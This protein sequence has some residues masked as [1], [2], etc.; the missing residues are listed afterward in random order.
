MR[1]RDARWFR[2]Y[3]LLAAFVVLTVSA[4]LLTHYYSLNIYRQSVEENRLWAQKIESYERLE[5]SIAAIIAPGNEVFASIDPTREAE[6]YRTA[7][8]RY[9]EAM[10]EAERIAVVTARLTPDLDW[11]STLGEIDGLVSA[12]SSMTNETLALYGAN[13]ITEAA[14]R[15]VVADRL[16]G[17]ANAIIHLLQK[18]MRGLQEISLERQLSLTEEIRIAE[19]LIGSLVAL[20]VLALSLY[21]YRLSHRMAKNERRRIEQLRAVEASEQK[22]RE[23]AEGSIEGITVHRHGKPLFVNRTWAEFHNYHSPDAVIAVG[24]LSNI[25]AKEDREAVRRI[26]YS[27]Q[28]GPGVSRRYEYRAM[29]TDGSI[30]WL[31]CLERVILWQDQPAVQTT[32]IDITDRKRTEEKLRAALLKAEQA[33]SAR[34]RFL[35]A[36]SHDLRQPLQALSLYLPLLRKHISNPDALATVNAIGASSDSMRSLLDSLLDISKLDSGMVEANVGPTPILD[37]L[38]RL[39]IEVAPLAAEKSIRL[40]IVPSTLWVESDPTLL[41]NIIRNLLCNALRYTETGTVLVGARRHGDRVRIE[42]WDTGPG[43]AEDQQSR[44]FEEFYQAA[45]PNRSEMQGLGLGLAII[46]RLAGLLGHRISLRSRPGKGSV[47]GVEMAVAE[48]AAFDT[49]D[50]EAT[51]IA[52]DLAHMMVLL[53]E[54]NDD[55]RAAMAATLSNW[56]CDV[57]AAAKI[58]EAVAMTVGNGRTPDVIVTDLALR[59]GETGIEA[60]NRIRN[61]TG[62]PVPAIIVTAETDPDR[63]G[64]VLDNNIMMFHKPIEPE[65]LR[66]AL[67]G[68]VP[69]R[70]KYG[71]IGKSDPAASLKLIESLI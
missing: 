4:G 62:L 13:R 41:Q 32:A 8:A 43:I 51:G 46:D 52:G 56:R 3:L 24:N 36:A 64:N 15:I 54:D 14:G 28:H 38:D 11:R 55:V 31:E 27:L 53:I 40:R 22:F 29:R 7:I 9:R 69:N 71:I 37:I 26:R 18:D 16:Y 58:D 42:V 68:L 23:L 44:I 1:R 70:G 57:L 48:P 49:G 21:G 20:M 35:A 30:V 39:A 65:A 67:E 34:T 19:Y 47:F 50:T 25:V 17:E 33:T 6:R 60:I 2:A 59:D 66:L 45:Q 10:V 5:M 61:V 12:L 63:L